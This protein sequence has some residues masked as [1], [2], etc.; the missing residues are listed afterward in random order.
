MMHRLKPAG[1]TAVRVHNRR[2][3]LKTI[4]A[5]GPISRADL[6]KMLQMSEPTVSS[7]VEDL[8]TR[9]LVM[10]I[11]PGASLGGRRP[12]LIQFN[13]K[14]GYVAAVS[15]TG[16]H[17]WGG[18][19]DLDGNFLF[20]QEILWE[21]ED[22]NPEKIGQILI[23][24]AINSGLEKE[25]ILGAGIA[26]PGA[27]DS[28]R[29]ILFYAPSLQWHNV[30]LGP[31]ATE[32]SGLKVYVENDVNTAAMA[33]KT[34]GAARDLQNFILMTMD[35]GIG[36]A[37]FLKGDLYRGHRYAAGEIGLMLVDRQWINKGT[38]TDPS[39]FGFLERFAS[40]TAMI[41]QAKD[42]GVF[43]EG[44]DLDGF[45]SEAQQEFQVVADIVDQAT[46]Y[47]AAVIINMTA[48]LDPE[49]VIVGGSWGESSTLMEKL[50]E[51]VHAISPLRPRITPSS[52]G[53]KAS[54]VG[55]LSLAAKNAREDLLA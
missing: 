37:L 18:I 9:K 33:E 1:P 38:V 32:V 41:K 11:G 25:T 48:I 49:A 35:E 12:T 40:V 15:I 53:K 54:R 39:D 29:G 30:P 36:A 10:D 2:L 28:E 21:E 42:A 31:I 55:A 27:T 51:R 24:L 13:P 4:E 26:A 50:R 22:V 43:F 3:L 20:E 8:L 6:A 14:A 16:D 5:C 47:L 45:V 7:V 52:L 17:V 19:S 23:D 44:N 46:E 34:W